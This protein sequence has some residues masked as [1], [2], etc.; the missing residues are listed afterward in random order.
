MQPSIIASSKTTAR[1]LSSSITTGT[2]PARVRHTRHSTATVAGHTSATSAS[3]HFSSGSIASDVA[4]IASPAWRACRAVAAEAA[5][6]NARPVISRKVHAFDDR[7]IGQTAASSRAQRHDL[8]APGNPYVWIAVIR[9][10]ANRS[11]HVRAVSVIVHRV[12]IIVEGVD[13]H[14][15]VNIAV[16]IVVNRIP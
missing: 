15:I 11:R 10:G 5:I 3:G 12:A 6:D 4:A 16:A 9:G 1:S 13:P 7:S 14:V 2:T 8:N